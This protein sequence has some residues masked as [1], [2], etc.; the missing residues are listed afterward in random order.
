MEPRE[1]HGGSMALYI[2]MG[3]RHAQEGHT[4]FAC[5]HKPF[6]LEACMPGMWQTHDHC[7]S[8]GPRSL[9]WPR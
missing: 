7:P 9:N 1:Q 8:C 2:P 4:R 6:F 3:P 5:F